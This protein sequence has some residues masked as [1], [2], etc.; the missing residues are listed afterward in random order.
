MKI[1]FVSSETVPYAASGGLADVAEALPIALKEEGVD[2]I[3]VMPKYRAVEDNYALKREFSFIVEAGGQ[4]KVADVYA[5]NYDGVLTY[6]I[7]NTDYFERDG[8]YGYTDDDERFGFFLQGNI[9]DANVS[10]LKTGCYS[11]E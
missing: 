3:R 10:R 6:F 5:L 4:A 2:I 9:R 8:L 1:L 7:G 11:F